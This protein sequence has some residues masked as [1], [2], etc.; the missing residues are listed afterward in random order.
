M[1][2]FAHHH[3]VLFVRPISI[4]HLL[5]KPSERHWKPFEWVDSN[6]W[7]SS[8]LMLPFG[9][10]VPGVRRL[11][12]AR[13]LRVVR[14]AIRRLGFERFVLWFYAPMSQYLAGRLG[15]SA[16]VYDCTDAWER[17]EKTPPSTIERDRVLTAQA[18]VLF[19]GTT[20][21]YETRRERN[22]NCH[23]FTCAVDFEHFA[24]V[25]SG[26]PDD[27]VGIPHPI[28]GYTGLIDEARVDCRLI[29]RLAREHPE[30][31]IVLVGPVQDDVLLRALRHPNIH[32][33]GLKSYDE[34]PRYVAAFDA[35]IVPY[36]VNAATHHINPT[37]LLEY[38]AAGKPVVSTALD[39]IKSFYLNRLAIAESHDEFIHS[40]ER[41]LSNATVLPVE[42][43]RTLA[44]T[45]S[46]DSVS[47]A[48]LGI[49]EARLESGE[50]HDAS[51]EPERP[52]ERA[53]V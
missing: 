33:L 44:A 40:I 45:R 38:M 47:N 26:T 20:K 48:M 12:E 11:N 14:L 51:E 50:V 15:E 28:V 6:L 24:E 30:W 7:V 19:A 29:E 5:T 9:R 35:A 49:V 18:D 3:R 52:C 2:R 10:R 32:F 53:N 23:L 16:V 13:I 31:S 22:P 4:A 21:V 34:L 17:F 27:L 25:P 39:E 43:N 46:W 41:V 1:S 42:S 36:R 37:K 8:P